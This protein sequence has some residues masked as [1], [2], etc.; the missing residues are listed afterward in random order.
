MHT[1]PQ[2]L[3]EVSLRGSSRWLDPSSPSVVERPSDLRRRAHVH[4]DARLAPRRTEPAEEREERRLA[5]RLQREPD[6]MAEPGAAE[7]SL[8][9]TRLF[10]DTHEVV[11]VDRRAVLAGDLRRHDRRS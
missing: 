10:L 8:Q 1:G 3:V 4:P 7:R 2:D 6:T 11:D 9:R 5:L